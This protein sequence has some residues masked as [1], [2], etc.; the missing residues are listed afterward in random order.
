MDKNIKSVQ[1]ICGHFEYHKNWLKGLDETW[2]P[3]KEDLT[4]CI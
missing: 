1:K 2:Q 4:V 3:I